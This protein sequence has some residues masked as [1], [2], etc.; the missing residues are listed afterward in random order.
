MGQ[1]GFTSFRDLDARSAQQEQPA[2]A[3]GTGGGTAMDTAA[4][5]AIGV[6]KGAANTAIGLGQLFN[7]YVPGVSWLNE[8]VYGQPVNDAAFQSAR[9]D[10]ATPTNTA[11]K[12]GFGAEQIGEF[13]VP[14]G[15]A[16]KVAKAAEIAKSGVLTL[17]QGGSPT[18]AG[19]SAGI[20]AVIPGARGVQRMSEGFRE[21]AEKEM[22]RALGATKEGMK[23]EASRLAPEMLER[24]VKGSRQAMLDHARE[25]VAALGP[26]IGAEVGAAATAG[27]TINGLVVRGAIQESRD[28]LMVKN[29]TGT[30]VPIEGS[31]AVVDKLTRL[32]E[33]VESLGDDIP[34]DKAQR[35]KTVWDRLVSK[36]GLYGQKATAT[37]T[38]NASAWAT[39]EGAT[40]FRDML[41]T[42]SPTLA[43]L[44][45]EYAFWRGLRNVLSETQRR[46]QAQSG[47]LV[48]AGMGGAGAIVGGMT[49]DSAT[50]HVQNAVLGGFA[51]KKLVQVIQSPAW[52]T[53]VTGPMKQK[54][55]EALASGNAERVTTAIGRIVAAAPG[56]VMRPV[57]SH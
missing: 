11:Q 21:G 54:L 23:V 49:G 29:A 2:Q 57:P 45:R 27:T 8:Q 10:F 1:Q 14:V 24:G 26:Q 43:D 48:S 56:Q 35:I 19:V 41:A 32:D 22:A 37:A 3:Q 51:G 46:T 36:A 53:T 34:F 20:T 25:R 42:G 16:G 13:F 40:A 50:D 9:Q 33:F 12:V 39:R 31:Q 30:L 15:A 52:R 55:A 4:D 38:D 7:R 17:A 47:G 5:V 18:S 6:G 28:A 44:N